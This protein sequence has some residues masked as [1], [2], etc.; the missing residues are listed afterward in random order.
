MHYKIFIHCDDDI[1]LC[2]RIVRDVKERGREV[3]N[4]LFQYN[5]FVKRSFDNYIKPTMNY[6]DMIVPGSRNN[7]VS[8][9]FIV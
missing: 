9:S 3:D 2:R 4:I 6:A 5:T 7:S 8:V 1:R